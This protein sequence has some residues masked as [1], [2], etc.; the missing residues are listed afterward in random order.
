LGAFEHG[1]Q[2][3]Y[4]PEVLFDYRTAK[5]SMLTRAHAFDKQVGEF[6]ALKHGPLYRHAFLQ[7]ANQQE[8]LRWTFRN[9]WRL[10]KARFKQK[11]QK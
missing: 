3:A 2:F 8:S 5:E 6:I 4:V 10:L 9:L 1:W 11:F 7:L